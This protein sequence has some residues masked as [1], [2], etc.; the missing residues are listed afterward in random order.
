MPLAF[1]LQAFPLLTPAQIDQLRAYGIVGATQAGVPC[2]KS[3]SLPVTLAVGE[4]LMAIK[5]VHRFLDE[6]G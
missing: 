4:G 3:A 1:A 5:V 2:S 6:R